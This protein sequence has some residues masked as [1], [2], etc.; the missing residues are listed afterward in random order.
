MLYAGNLARARLL[1][2]RRRTKTQLE[3]TWPQGQIAAQV[4]QSHAV[5]LFRG[6]FPER[7][8]LSVDFNKKLLSKEENGG[9]PKKVSK[10][11]SK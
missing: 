5:V 11:V 2:R 4:A 1:V 8:I 10:K 3:T 9:F 6:P 7:L